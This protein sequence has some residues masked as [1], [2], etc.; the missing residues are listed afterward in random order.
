MTAS[1]RMYSPDQTKQLLP[2]GSSFSLLLPRASQ[3][4]AGTHWQLPVRR[5]IDL[6]WAS[7]QHLT[8]RRWPERPPK[9]KDLDAVCM[10]AFQ[11]QLGGT[12]DPVTQDV[13]ARLKALRRG[14]K[15]LD[16]GLFIDMFV[17]MHTVAGLPQM[18]PAASMA[19]RRT[20]LGIRLR[21]VRCSARARHCQ[22]RCLTAMDIAQYGNSKTR[23]PRRRPSDRRRRGLHGLSSLNACRPS[24]PSFECA[25]RSCPSEPGRRSCWRP[26]L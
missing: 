1:Y 10:D 2:D 20:A 15:L 25:R 3:R 4:G 21:Q 24:P 18:P 12:A 6:M 23:G 9:L 17:S 13:H 7:I 22:N 26:A 5:V 11:T 19:R 8:T 16:A 14:E